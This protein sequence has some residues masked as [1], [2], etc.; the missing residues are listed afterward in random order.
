MVVPCDFGLSVSGLEEIESYAEF[1]R[2][3]RDGGGYESVSGVRGTR[4]MTD[5]DF[6]PTVVT[7]LGLHPILEM[8]MHVA[9]LTGQLEFLLEGNINLSFLIIASQ[10]CTTINY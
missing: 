7:R 9:E 8:S 4:R 3:I 5:M 6:P 2:R 10:I 1:W